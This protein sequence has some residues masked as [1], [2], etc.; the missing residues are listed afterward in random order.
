MQKIIMV[1]N[2]L[3]SGLLTCCAPADDHSVHKTKDI[4]TN[5]NA[6]SGGPWIYFSEGANIVRSRCAPDALLFDRAN[7]QLDPVTVPAGLFFQE[8]NKFF[9]EE[10]PLLEQQK[11]AAF[12][13]IDRIDVRLLD[14]MSTEP[15][16]VRTDIKPLIAAKEL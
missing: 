6:D 7:C 9:G 4:V 3:V 5:I 13:K 15:D 16:P 8:V 14:L 1:A 12:I 11:A 2:I 10:L